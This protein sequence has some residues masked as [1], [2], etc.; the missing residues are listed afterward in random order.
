MLQAYLLGFIVF[1]LCVW[2]S[3]DRGTKL[4]ESWADLLFFI[5]WPLS[6]VV[7]VIMKCRGEL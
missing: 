5:F 1:T 6:L 2:L 4:V 3:C 7:G